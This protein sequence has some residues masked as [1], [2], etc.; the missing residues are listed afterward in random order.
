MDNVLIGMDFSSLEEVEG[1]GGVFYDGGKP[2]ELPV[3]LARHGVRASRIRLWLDPHDSE[4]GNYGGGTCDLDCVIR[5]AKRSK[6]LDM[7][8]LLDFHY[9]DFW[10]DPGKQTI[11][12][13]WQNLSLDE[14]A[15]ALYKYTRDVLDTMRA[16]GVYPDM[17]QVGNEITH[18]TLW[19]LAK[20]EFD[21]PE[22]LPSDF[23]NLAKVVRAGCKAVRESGDAKIMLHLE[24]SGN[25]ELWRTWFDNMIARGVE[26]DIIGASYY[27]VWH[28]GFDR[29][30]ANMDDMAQRYGKPIHI[31]ETAY[32]F[33]KEPHEACSLAGIA[34]ST[35]DVTADG[36]PPSFPYTKEGQ[37]DFLLALIEMTANI[38]GGLGQAV[39]YWEPGWLPKAGTTW[40]S[41]AAKIYVNEADK[42]GGNEWAPLCLFDYQGEATPA[43]LAL[44]GEQ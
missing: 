38:H 7:K 1:F 36:T 3:I 14:M 29:L 23:D 11:P 8:L 28:G 26:F 12:K 6:A 20:L 30:K 5:I 15:E 42:E 16:E 27:P 21:K 32:A 31:V 43:L 17:V 22:K 13:A 19:P 10:C 34:N 4:G 39:W 37:R 35:P 25:N 9:S 40:A 24:N 44:G 33:T 2:D 41:D 18:G